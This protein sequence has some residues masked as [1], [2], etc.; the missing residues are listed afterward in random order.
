MAAFK[1]A[2]QLGADAI[3][4]DVHM[5]SDGELVVIHDEALQRTTDGHGFVSD[6]TL[7]ELRRLDAGSW[8]S[9]EFGGEQIPLLSD[10][11]ALPLVPVIELKV[12]DDRYPGIEERLIQMLIQSGRISEA[13]V[14]SGDPT[15]LARLRASHPGVRTLSF[16]EGTLNPNSHSGAQPSQ[17]VMFAPPMPGVE[18]SIQQVRRTGHLVIGT[19]LWVQEPWDAYLTRQLKAGLTGVF[20]DHVEQLHAFI[21]GA[22]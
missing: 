3:E 1:A 21:H 16:R 17:A 12:G 13:V 11:L 18:R 7:A 19:T 20:T 9:P 15:P 22:H 5:S 14:I 4:C 8:F 10:V 6:H 2:A